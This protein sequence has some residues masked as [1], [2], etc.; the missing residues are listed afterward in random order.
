ME[1][2]VDDL[3]FNFNVMDARCETLMALEFSFM[4]FA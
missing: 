2:T 1:C 3:Q 4:L